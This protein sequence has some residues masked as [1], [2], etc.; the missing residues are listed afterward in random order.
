MNLVNHNIISLVSALT[1]SVFSTTAGATTNMYC[2]GIDSDADVTIL[3][4]G[5]PVLS[6]LEADVFLAGKGVST[7]GVGN[8]VDANIVQFAADKKHLH[9]DLI[10]DQ[11]DIHLVSIRL[12]RYITDEETVQIGLLQFRDKTPVG[13]ICEGP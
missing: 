5:G 9:L 8:G 13:I 3:F 4:G 2:K 10:N 11:A 1:L 7:R 12:L 6:A